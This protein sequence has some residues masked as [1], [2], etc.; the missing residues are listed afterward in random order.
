MEFS[1]ECL[2]AISISMAFIW[3]NFGQFH[4]KNLMLAGRFGS[5]EKFLF[6]E[7]KTSAFDDC[8]W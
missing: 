4:L 6:S 1:G 3:I 8:N 5:V 7:R 2:A